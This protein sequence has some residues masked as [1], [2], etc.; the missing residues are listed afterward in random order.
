MLIFLEKIEK[1]GTNIDHTF[2]F[3]SEKRFDLNDFNA[4]AEQ[5]KNG[6]F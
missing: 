1:F 4:F 3:V 6:R 5:S 2:L